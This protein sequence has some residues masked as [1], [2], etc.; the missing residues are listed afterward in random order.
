MK[1]YNIKIQVSKNISNFYACYDLME[2][3]TVSNLV[4]LAVN[5]SG[6]NI[7]A[8]EARFDEEAFNNLIDTVFLSIDT[9]NKWEDD[10][11]EDTMDESDDDECFYYLSD[12]DEA[13]E[14]EDG[15]TGAAYNRTNEGSDTSKTDEVL[16]F[17]LG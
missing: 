1:Y 10:E 16:D 5:L 15:D 3:T 4:A 17:H 12:D 13:C 2:V 9:L 14:T 8:T 7:E 11:D 6:L